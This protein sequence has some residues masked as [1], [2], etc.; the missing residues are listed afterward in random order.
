MTTQQDIVKHWTFTWRSL[1]AWRAPLPMR[2]TF[3]PLKRGGRSVG[4]AWSCQGR[5]V[6]KLTGKL[7]YDLATALHEMAHLAA[8]NSEHHGEKWR[9][10]FVAATCE[11]LGLTSDHFETDVPYADLDGQVED[12]VAAW[13][14][15]TGQASVLRAI[16]VM[17]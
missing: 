1:A 14:D 7:A 9:E 10:L 17:A 8:P 2:I 12:A 16:G 4:T 5:A 6:V 11:A 3:K 15:R 13:L